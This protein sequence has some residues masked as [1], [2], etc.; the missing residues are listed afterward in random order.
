M[1]VNDLMWIDYIF[2]AICDGKCK[3]VADPETAV[4]ITLVFRDNDKRPM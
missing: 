4:K 1:Y 3:S 2:F